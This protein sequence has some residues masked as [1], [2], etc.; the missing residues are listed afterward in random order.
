MLETVCN[1][2]AFIAFP[3]SFLLLFSP[4]AIM[5]AA[6][7]GERFYGLVCSVVFYLMILDCVAVGTFLTT[8]ILK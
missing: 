1:F 7:K 6:E 2:S 8:L 3:L 5:A 4:G